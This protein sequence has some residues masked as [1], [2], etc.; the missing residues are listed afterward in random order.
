MYAFEWTATAVT[1]SVDSVVYGT[2]CTTCSVG[3]NAWTNSSNPFYFIVNLAIGGD[4]PGVAPDAA[5]MPGR[6]LVDWIRVW[7][8]DDGVSFVNAPATSPLSSSSSTATAAG[9]AASSSTSRSSAASTSSSRPSSSSTRSSSSSR[10]SSST[11]TAAAP[12]ASNNAP[13]TLTDWS[14]SDKS[15]SLAWHE[16]FAYSDGT[17]PSASMWN[18][19]TGGSGWGNRELEYYTARPVNSYISNG[20]LIVA[21]LWETYN[22]N[23]HHVSPYDD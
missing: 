14:P 5:S 21:G 12:T 2:V 11:T 4:F 13:V 20:T 8:K 17:Q 15:Y 19:E 10:S 3:T 18:W 1:V 22:G 23:N 7:Q 9:G 6:L 16:E